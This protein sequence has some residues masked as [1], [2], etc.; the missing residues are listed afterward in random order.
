METSPA[1]CFASPLLLLYAM[2]VFNNIL[3]VSDDVFLLENASTLLRV[4][5]TSAKEVIF[6][7]PFVCLFVRRITQKVIDGF[8]Q[9]FLG[10]WPQD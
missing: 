5:I 6:L 7:L 10:G 8:S 4:F 2:L 3:S 1:F 9:K